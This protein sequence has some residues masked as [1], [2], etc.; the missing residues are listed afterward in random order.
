[1]LLSVVI[2]NFNVK[3]FLEQCLASV[4]AASRGMDVEVIVV[5]NA[6]DDNSINYLQPLFPEVI[7]INNTV[8]AGFAKACNQG[9][10]RSRGRF[11][12]FLNPDTIVPEDCFSRCIAFMDATPDA[13]AL[14]VKMLDGSGRFLKE[15]KRAFPSPMTSLY[16]LSG[17]ARLFP[18]SKVFA[19]YHLGHLDENSNHAVEV[20]AGA[21]ML[22]RRELLDATGAFDEQF[23]MYGEDVDLSYRLQQ[24][25]CAATGT[26]YRN[27]YFSETP[28]IHFKGESTRKA[29]MN[30]VRMFYSAMSLF[31]KK[32][33]WRQPR[34]H[35]Q[36]FYTSRYLGTRYIF[37]SKQVYPCAGLPLID[38]ILIL[39]SFWMMKEVWAEYVKPEVRYESRLLWIAFPAFTVVYLIT[40]YY[41]GLYDR[42]YRRVELIQSTLVATLVVL[43][44]YSLLPEHYRF[45]RGIILFGALMAFLLIGLLRR[46]LIAAGV[47][48]KYK[49]H[50]QAAST[51]AVATKEEY[52]SIKELMAVANMQEKLLGRVAVDANTENTIGR[53]PVLTSLKRT[54]PFSELVLVAGYLS[55]SELINKL[56]QLPRGIRI[57]WHGNG[58]RSIVGS[59]SKRQQRR[60]TLARKWLPTFKSTL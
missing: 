22:V 52:A 41:A 32:T 46:V 37:C 30:Y 10:K 45:S 8:N 29:S 3:H 6:S 2:V 4:R 42:W 9:W 40:A 27:Y 39:L 38:A 17:L 26:N 13:G 51:I 16:K 36:F 23:F 15:S 58:T 19:R 56:N 11:V 33:L 53:W 59:D 20:L 47:V 60:I 24:Q 54:I 28:I 31:V 44:T 14:G 34:G 48:S 55:Y 12:L 5:D 1:M 21:F 57:K 18:R 49:P 35:I 25:P 7:F 50:D 43:A